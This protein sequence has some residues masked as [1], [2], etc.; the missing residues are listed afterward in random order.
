MDFLKKF[1]R[2]PLGGL[3]NN[4]CKWVV[5]KWQNLL[6]LPSFSVGPRYVISLKG[7]IKVHGPR[8]LFEGRTFCFVRPWHLMP[9]VWQHI[10]WKR[11]Y[12]M[13]E[14]VRAATRHGGALSF[15]GRICFRF[16]PLYKCR[17]VCKKQR[18]GA[19]R[20]MQLLCVTCLRKRSTDFD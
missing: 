11:N 10:F 3:C 19:R 12:C 17:E 18:N 5:K 16:T 15:Q 2:T 7:N 1:R 13:A 20:F 6:T 4:T 14:V 8:K 9:D